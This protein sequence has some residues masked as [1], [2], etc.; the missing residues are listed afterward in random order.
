MTLIYSQTKILGLEGNY[1]NPAYFDG[2]IDA[3]ATLVF[4]E[5]EDIAE[6]AK[7]KGIKVKGFTKQPP[8]KAEATTEPKPSVDTE[9][10]VEV[11]EVVEAPK[12]RRTRKPR[13]KKDN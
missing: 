7:L 5:R 2:N 11:E 4:T 9:K 3:G 8:K 10:P 1:S 6:C 12:K 13:V